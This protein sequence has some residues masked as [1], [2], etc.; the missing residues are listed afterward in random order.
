MGMPNKLPA[1]MSK[2]IKLYLKRLKWVDGDYIENGAYF[3]GGM[4]D[5][6]YCAFS[7]EVQFFVRA[8]TRFEAKSLVMEEIPNVRFY[9]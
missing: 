9:R 5:Y 6:I 3:G 1:D 4:G 2:P 7:E 8:K